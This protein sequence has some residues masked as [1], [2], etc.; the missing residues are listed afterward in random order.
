MAKTERQTE[1]GR[2]VCGGMCDRYV[3]LATRQ[4]P[5]VATRVVSLPWKAGSHADDLFAEAAAE[6]RE[7]KEACGEM[8]FQFSEGK[9]EFIVLGS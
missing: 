5:L 6:W 9:Q 8:W 1:K 4:Q 2:V 7:M 3:D